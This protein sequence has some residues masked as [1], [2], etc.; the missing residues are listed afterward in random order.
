VLSR[1]LV[2]LP[3]ETTADRNT[4]HILPDSTESEGGQS[5]G[6][7]V[8]VGCNGHDVGAIGMMGQLA[9]KDCEQRG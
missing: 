9:R 4:A 8:R 7:T 6:R 2:E 1:A 3:P 5:Q